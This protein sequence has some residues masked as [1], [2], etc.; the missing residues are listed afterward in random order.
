[1]A[2][3]VGAC[4]AG[5]AAGGAAPGPGAAAAASTPGPGGFTVTARGEPGP[6]T[7]LAFRAP[8]LYVGSPRGL[9]RSNVDSD[10]YEWMDAVAP[11]MGSRI[12]AL[13]VE[14]GG[15]IWVATEAGLS[16]LSRAAVGE[17][18]EPLAPLP[19]VTFLAPVE[20][21]RVPTAWAAG[22][23]GLFRVEGR[24][25][26]HVGALEGA[27]VTSLDRDRDGKT[28]WVGTRGQGVLR[29]EGGRVEPVL[30]ADDVDVVGAAVTAAGMRVV[31]GRTR[32]GDGARLYFFTD[33][34]TQAFRAQ[35]D[36]R[37][38]RLFD[39]GREAV[40]LAGAPGAERAYTLRPFDKGDAV[41]AGSVRFV[42]VG[43]GSGERWAA[44][45]LD[46][47]PPSEVTTVIAGGGAGVVFYGTEHLGVARGAAPRAKFL[48][49][50]L[51][52]GDAER[53]H[54]ACAPARFCYVVTEGPRAWRTDGDSYAEARVG[55][56]DDGETLAVVGDAAGA[57]YALTTEP[58]FAGLV[59][60]T[61]P[62]GELDRWEPFMR[63][64][65]ALPVRKPP[66]VSIAAVSPEGTLWVG[67][68]A[69]ASDGSDETVGFGALEI[70]LQTKH[71]IQ[72][73][74]AGGGDHA[75][76]DAVPLPQA[77]TG[78]FF[79]QPTSL[80]FSSLSGV[81]RFASGKLESWGENQGMPSELVHGV[82]RG[83]DGDIWAA[84][85]E[86]VA[87]FDGKDW[88]PARDDDSAGARALVRDRA[89]RTWIATAKGLRVI[90]PTSRNARDATA[91]GAR[92][93]A[94]ASAGTTVLDADM[95]DVVLDRFGR[96]WA[97]SSEAVALVDSAAP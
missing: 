12:S 91:P 81:T 86:G 32:G 67:V 41:P 79:D 39:G 80:W 68:R 14:S 89:G 13:G 15:A 1:M 76:P 49:G 46:E 69:G 88:R 10:E 94:T 31:G 30:R 37:A 64:P 53:L 33:A 25:A 43:H 93:G 74:P 44:V 62:A 4:A 54:V 78:V 65:L 17:R 18:Y 45:P 84:T 29:I 48:S 3:G 28:L 34:G 47:R 71:A 97:L 85:S 51:L 5:R 9:R 19:R 61:L 2:V 24:Q 6:I 58:R 36:V 23:D 26:T 87:R 42:P 40:L 7:A 95:R 70:D 82:G 20:G 75:R 16:R 66:A 56:A 92:A 72:H 63:V 27:A 11:L 35:P 96:V 57:L 22:P 21:G 60:T 59:I 90:A 38:A 52:V 73:P 50:S 77:L 83:P 55:E 8:Y